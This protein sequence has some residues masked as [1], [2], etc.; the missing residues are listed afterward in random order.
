[1]GRLEGST[2]LVTGASSGIGAACARRF[3]A[4]GARLVLW[5]RR[6]ERLRTL[7]A[8]L[9]DDPGSP[10]RVAG[11][12]VRDRAAVEAS[13]GALARDGVVPDV[14]VNNA[15]LAAGLDPLQ[16][17]DPE[18]WDRMI[19][20]NLKGLLYV[21]R[22]LLPH[23]LEA[24]RGHVINVGSTAGHQVYPRG[25]VYNATKFGVR[26]LTE[27]LNLD[28]AGTPLRASSVDPGFVE[29]EFSVV[30]FHGD[31][32]RADAVYEGFRPLAADDVA[33]AIH[34]VASA[35]EHVNVFQIIL[36]PAAQRNAYV[37]DR[38]G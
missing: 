1:M 34:Y 12:D 30:R 10:V 35:P 28:L 24:G 7:A 36:L 3:A 8:E 11:V 6:E 26:A 19:D 17:G 38:A 32:E 5:A 20:T 27:G 33:E 14:L 2:V 4:S 37:V 16:E 22:A 13:A 25:N 23:M 18:D 31:E 21:S 29:T 9:G 15:G